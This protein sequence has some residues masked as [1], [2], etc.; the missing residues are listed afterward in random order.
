[1]GQAAAVNEYLSAWLI[2]PAYL[3]A[4]VLFLLVFVFPR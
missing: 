3:P 4:I 1:V 2:V